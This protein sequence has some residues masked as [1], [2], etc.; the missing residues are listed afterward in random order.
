MPDHAATGAPLTDA[1]VAV[2]AAQ[3]GAAA[4]RRAYGTHQM[5]VAKSADDFATEADYAAEHAIL[6]LFSDQRPA[7]ARVAEETGVSGDG[8][9][10]RRWLVDPLCGTANF[11]ANTPLACVNVALAADRHV[12]VGASADPISGEVFW[13]DG[14]AAW[15]RKEAV[16]E[17]LTPAATSR[18][19]DVNCDGPADVPFV[20]GQ[21][22]S[23]PE[24]LAAWKPRVL[25][26]TLA[27]AWVAAGRRAA[28]ISDG[29]MEGNIHFAAGI[30]L[31]R[32]A[33]CV[34]T[35]L[36]GGPLNGGR[37]LIAAADVATH[38]DMVQLVRPHLDAVLSR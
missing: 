21:L 2:I 33:G 8:S 26:T 4:V 7:D 36:F 28:Y 27:V 32:A 35:D 3:A 38:A 25:S 34:V 23:D 1:E 5:Q 31:C 16:D 12:K 9:A 20:G 18:L 29:P 17:P 37:G 15:C 19:I 22:L 24:F 30:A 6:S 10:H 14:T 11:A 13:T